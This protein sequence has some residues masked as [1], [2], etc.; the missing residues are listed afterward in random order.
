MQTS[1]ARR[2]RH[3]R[4]G[5]R[6][7]SGGAASKVAIALPLFLFFTFVLLGVVGATAAVGAYGYYSQGLQDPK[8]LLS[9]LDFAEETVV[10]DRTGKVELA[11]FGQVK[12][13]VLTFNQIP[14]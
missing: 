2:R 5:G 4:N 7:R 12:R 6:P 3:R 11:R 8:K 9:S 13:N 1:L 14:P 10:Y